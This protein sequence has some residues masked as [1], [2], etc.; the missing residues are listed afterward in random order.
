MHMFLHLL[1]DTCMTIVRCAVLM[2]ALVL[3]FFIIL[4]SFYVLASYSALGGWLC[5]PLGILWISF[6]RWL[7]HA[8]DVFGSFLYWLFS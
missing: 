2:F 8:H 3:C 7:H 6:L 4:G 5:L 1:K